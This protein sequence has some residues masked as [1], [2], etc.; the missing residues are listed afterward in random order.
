[1]NNMFDGG[2]EL[3]RKIKPREPTLREREMVCVKPRTKGV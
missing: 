1:M 2:L 3:A